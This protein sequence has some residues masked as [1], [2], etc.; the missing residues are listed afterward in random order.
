LFLIFLPVDLASGF[1]VMD[2]IA[3]RALME[4]HAQQLLNV[5]FLKRFPPANLL[6][7]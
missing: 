5:N 4:D 7:P 1:L 6:K 3:G 2:V